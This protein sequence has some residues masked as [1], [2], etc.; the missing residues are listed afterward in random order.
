MR[1]GLISRMVVASGLLAVIVGGAF[2]VVLFAIEDVR[3]NA[4]KWR[5]TQSTIVAAST[6][7]RNVDRLETA[8][9]GYLVT[10]DTRFMAPA[11]AAQA[12]IPNGERSVERLATGEGKAQSA[13][14]QRLVEAID[15][16][17]RRSAL[18][19]LNATVGGG[20]AAAGVQRTLAAERQV[21]AVHSAYDAFRAPEDVRTTV[22]NAKIAA[23]QHRVEV[24]AAIGIAAAMLLI[25]VYAGYVTYVIVLPLR[26]AAAM[27]NQLASGDLSARTPEGA[28]A[29]VGALQHSLNVMAGSLEQSQDELGAVLAEQAALRRVATL[30][31]RE[32][33]PAEVF[34]TVIREVGLLSG[35]DLA[36]MERYESPDVVVGV[37]SWSREDAPELSVGERFSL[38]G[39]SIAAL[40]Q[41]ARG[42]VRVDSFADAHGPI[43]EEAQALGIRTSVGCP[44]VVDDHLWGVVA[45]SSRS[46]T[47]FPAGTESQLAEFTKLA[48]FAI[49]NTEKRTEIAAS[50]ARIVAATED[51]RRRVVRDLH[52]GAQQRLVHTVVTLKMAQQSVAA[53]QEDD[54]PALLTEALDN[55]SQA[56]A[57]LRELSHGILPV[58]LTRGGL[59]ASVD[60]LATRMPVPVANDVTANRLPPA[61]EATAYFVIAEALTNVAK[62]AHARH[63]EV[64]ARIVDGTLAVHVRDD[65]IGGAVSQGDGLVGMADRLA[66]LDGELRIE[67]PA[68][69]GTL[70]AAEIPL[71]GAAVEG[72]G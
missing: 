4:H 18:P 35:A 55:A 30:V 13:R 28:V 9:R 2:V 57:E 61:V 39:A 50:R 15:E 70:I 40:V 63:A 29:E 1:H 52:D 53:A 5:H 22:G 51:E 68:V 12:A 3:S 10:R 23:A 16:Y 6:L 48:A 65:G 14:A 27:A 36:R 60:A 8:L 24:T 41:A 56:M 20:A 67:S 25:L 64:A 38:E 37:A 19:V 42:P 66:V 21:D 45:A 11:N 34:E 32:A 26:R 7:L 17:L 72:R 43:A 33:A 44:I 62:H 31:A 69:G 59:R 71:D 58:V 49:A 54:V 46:A 47:P